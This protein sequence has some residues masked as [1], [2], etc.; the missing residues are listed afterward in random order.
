MNENT[1]TANEE[2]GFF[3]KL[4]QDDGVQRATAGIVVA[5]IVAG[6]KEMLFGRK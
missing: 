6:T 4:V 1:N 5:I 2:P 3:G